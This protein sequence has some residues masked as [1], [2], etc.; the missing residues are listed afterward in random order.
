MLNDIQA[1]QTKVRSVDEI[2]RWQI[3]ALRTLASHLE[4]G[5]RRHLFAHLKSTRGESLRALGVSETQKSSIPLEPQ[6]ETQDRLLL[7]RARELER[8]GVLRL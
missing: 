8:I 2:L 3:P 7:N 6:S 1:C 5:L 4:L